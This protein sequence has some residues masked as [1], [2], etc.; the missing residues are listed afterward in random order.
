MSTDLVSSFFDNWQIY[1][2]I[3]SN[4]YMFHRDF[5]DSLATR[6]PEREKKLSVLDLGCGDAWYISQLLKSYPVS[7][8]L[9][10]DLS[11]H[12]LGYARQNLSHINAPAELVEC[13][14]RDI[15]DRKES[16]Y[17]LIYSS[18][19]IHHVQQEEKGKLLRDIYQKLDR[20][21]L[22][23]IID[24]FRKEGQSRPAYLEDYLDWLSREWKEMSKSEIQL[25]RSHIM[26]FDFPDAIGWFT[27]FARSVGFTV[28]VDAEPQGRHYLLVLKKS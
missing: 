6:L 21:G 8:Y 10:C 18:Y 26:A 4:N 14:L 2:K 3:I 9:G 1:L 7:R 12:V 5:H 13:D 22:A 19:A 11:A 16:V 27:D 24:V 20:Q 25:I 17:D 28:E 23:V 15:L